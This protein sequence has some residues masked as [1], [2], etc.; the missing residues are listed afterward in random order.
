M[1]ERTHREFE[2]VVRRRWTNS[3]NRQVTSHTNLKI[4]SMSFVDLN[5][6]LSSTFGMRS[7]TELYVKSHVLIIKSAHVELSEYKVLPFAFSS[8]LATFQKAITTIVS[9]LIGVST[10]QY[11]IK[12]NLWSNKLHDKRLI[13]LLER[14]RVIRMGLLTLERAYFR[15]KATVELCVA[16]SH[17]QVCQRNWFLSSPIVVFKESKPSSS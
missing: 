8:F 6:S 17:W 10:H 13:L 3:L 9:D 12:V 2:V 4:S 15:C 7:Y 16:S 1:D 11:D 5:P 14:N